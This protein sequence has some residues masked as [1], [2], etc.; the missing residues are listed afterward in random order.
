MVFRLSDQKKSLVTIDNSGRQHLKY[1]D[2]IMDEDS[3]LVYSIEGN[4]GPLSARADIQHKLELQYF[5]SDE[6]RRQKIDILTLNVMT[7]TTQNF[8]LVEQIEIRL[9][10]QQ[11]FSKKYENTIPRNFV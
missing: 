3:N 5:A 4:G 6:S 2:V 9:N 10:G 11:F 1:E 7:S 8:C